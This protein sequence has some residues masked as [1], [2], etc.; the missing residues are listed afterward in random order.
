MKLIKDISQFESDLKENVYLLS[1][2]SNDSCSV[3]HALK[4]K[5][6]DIKDKDLKSVK[7]VEIPV[8]DFPELAVSYSVFTTPAIIFFIQGKEYF[9]E[10]RYFSLNELVDRINKLI[11]LFEGE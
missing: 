3:C 11:E 7:I 1:F 2:F 8:V 6:K 10:V 5:I 9:R 4:S